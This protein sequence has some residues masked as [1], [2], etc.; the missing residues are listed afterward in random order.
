MSE[1]RMNRS[2][3]PDAASGVRFSPIS[4]RLERIEGQPYGSCIGRKDLLPIDLCSKGIEA[5]EG[6]EQRCSLALLPSQARERRPG[7]GPLI[8]AFGNVVS[9]NRM[10]AELEKYCTPCVDDGT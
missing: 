6:S 8:Q 10:C 4:V 3:D 2:A 7:R 9:Q 5:A 1:Q